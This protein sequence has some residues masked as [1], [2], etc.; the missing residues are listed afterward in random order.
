MSVKAF[1]ESG[2][3]ITAMTIYV[4]KMWVWEIEYCEETVV[5]LG[6]QGSYHVMEMWIK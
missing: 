1:Q 4:E 3:L 6:Y 2:M 5:G